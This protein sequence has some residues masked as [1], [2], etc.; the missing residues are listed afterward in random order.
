ME[1]VKGTNDLVDGM[2]QYTSSDTAPT[3]ITLNQ[4]TEVINIDI[5]R[6]NSREGREAGDWGRQPP[7]ARELAFVA[8][9][10]EEKDMPREAPNPP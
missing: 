10:R 8:Q 6:C 3:R 2:E 4:V 9:Q 1:I 7:R 5:A